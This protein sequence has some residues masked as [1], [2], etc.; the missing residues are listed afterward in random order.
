MKVVISGFYGSRN[1]GDEAILSSII[2]SLREEYDNVEITVLSLLPQNVRED[3]DVDALLRADLGPRMFT[4]NWSVLYQALSE[5]DIHI[6]GGGGLLQDA[7]FNL[8]IFRY[9]YPVLLS[10]SAGTPV[11]LYS[12]GVGPIHESLNRTIV[13]DILN[14]VESIFVRDY[15]S[16]E[17]LMDI[18]VEKEITV[19]ADPVYYL[20]RVPDSESIT[21]LNSEGISTDDK[22]LAVSVRDY[23]LPQSVKPELADFLDYLSE[24][25]DYSVVFTPFGYEGEP[26]DYAVSNEIRS[27]MSSPSK[28]LERKYHPETFAGLLRQ[29]DM[30]IGMR[31]HS[32]ILGSRAGVPVLGLSYLPKVERELR[33]LGYHDEAFIQSIENTDSNDFREAYK[34]VL[35]LDHSKLKS[36]VIQAKDSALKPVK[37]VDSLCFEECSSTNIA[38][39]SV[40]VVALGVVLAVKELASTLND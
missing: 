15:Q 11:M 30:I 34:E 35:Q 19:C 20:N 22:L 31:L 17:T 25:E 40:T 6:I 18:G 37:E 7:H 33:K 5:A 36:N 23:N 14:M 10:K 26:S 3:H 9:L 21:A 29:M 16:K 38:T 4:M 1:L 32:I 13:R 28:I 39:S 27:Y 8:S 12:V 2:Y 24:V